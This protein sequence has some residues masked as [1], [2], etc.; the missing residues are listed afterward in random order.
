M[1]IDTSRT[2]EFNIGQIITLAYRQA[3]IL[4]LY[5]SPSD[6]Q[7]SYGKDLLQ[8]VSQSAHLQG[9]FAKVVAFYELDVLE[10]ISSYT[11]PAYVLDVL[12]AGMF[13]DPTQD[14]EHAN[15]ETICR[16]IS[17]AEW[18]E[19]SSKDATGR[20]TLMYEHRTADSVELRL[21][22]IPSASDAGG[23]LRLQVHRLRANMTDTTK[24]PEFE[25]YWSEYLVYETAQHIAFGSA[26][27]L[28]RVQALRDTA[29]NQ[30]RLCKGMANQRTNQRFVASQ[31]VRWKA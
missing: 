30:L 7:M 22:P 13:I 20:P 27:A 9:F 3:G 16:L 18:Q 26:L 24:T 6:A 4:S 1:T 5:Q 15:G 28:G 31:P 12:D 19:L 10:G 8:M 21:W 11:L 2:F 23:T 17:R 29:A 14:P 25:R